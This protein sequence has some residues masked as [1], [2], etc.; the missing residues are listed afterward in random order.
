MNN[1]NIP[2][3]L[4]RKNWWYRT[5]FAKPDGVAGDINLL[6]N[7]INYEANVWLNGKLLGNV[8][9][10]FIRGDFENL[11]VAVMIGSVSHG[12]TSSMACIGCEIGSAT[13][14]NAFSLPW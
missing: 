7:G 2:E 11:H 1:M 8:K 3:D 14:A 6:F 12:E 10:A 13:I 5:E 4:C 9:G